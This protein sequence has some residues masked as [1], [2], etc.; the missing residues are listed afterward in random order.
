MLFSKAL[1]QNYTYVNVIRMN[2]YEQNS[3]FSYQKEVFSLSILY[4]HDDLK[5]NKLNYL[6]LLSAITISHI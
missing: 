2:K 6:F 5:G 4:C 1:D 3:Q